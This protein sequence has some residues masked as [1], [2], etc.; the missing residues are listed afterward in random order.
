[1]TLGIW[2]GD[3]RFL[4]YANTD[5]QLFNKQT[6]SLIDPPAQIEVIKFLKF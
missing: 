6:H 3:D 5:L 2:D 1:M 4:T